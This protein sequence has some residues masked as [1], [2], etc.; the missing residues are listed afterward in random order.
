MAEINGTSG[1][2]TLNGTGDADVIRGLGGDDTINGGGGDDTLEGGDG[3]DTFTGGAGNDFINGRFGHNDVAIFSGNRADYLYENIVINGLNHVRITGLGAFASEGADTLLNVELARFADVTVQLG[4]SANNRPLLGQPMMLDQTVD[5][6]AP[7]TYIIPGTAFFDLD[8]DDALTLRATLADGAAL[9]S[10]LSFDAATR[11]FSGTPPVTT[12][13]QTLSVRVY[14][15]DDDLYDPEYEISDDFMITINQAAGAD[16]V[17]TAGNNILFGT[18]RNERM[19]GHSGDDVFYGS[20]GADI[21][22][23]NGSI[24]PGGDFVNYSASEAA[25]S[26]NLLTG[27]AS[28]GD[29]QGDVLNSI[30][31]VIG[32]RFADTILGTGGGD[33]LWGGLGDDTLD[34]I[35]GDDQIFG[36]G[37]N[38]TVIGGIGQDRLS[39]GAGSDQIN[40]GDGFDVLFAGE[41]SP[42]FTAPPN[43]SPAD[44][45]YA[46]SDLILD[47]GAEAD[48]LFGGN[49]DDALF[50]GYNDSADGGAHD[51]RGDSLYVSLMGASAGVQVDFTQPTVTLGSGTVT[52]FENVN[53]VEGSNFDDNITMRSTTGTF[54][55]AAVY[56]MGGNDQIVAGTWTTEIYGGD[57]H[58]GLDAT[59]SMA[60]IIVEGGA[61][62]DN[63]FINAGSY[64][65]RLDGGSGL[66]TL[67]SSGD[68]S[69]FN[70]GEFTGF[71]QIYMTDGQLRFTGSQFTYGLAT[72]TAIVGQGI[73][74]VEMDPGV[75]FA[76]KGFL[77]PGN[78]SFIVNGTS[79]NDVFKLG[80]ARHTINAGD[81]TDQIKGGAGIDTIDGGAGI[82][83]I[84]GGGGADILTGGAGNDVFRYLAVSDSTLA[85]ADRITDFAI[86]GD[87]LNFAKIDTN[88]TLAGDQAFTFIGNAAFGNTGVAQ[89]RFTDSFGDLLVQ[90]DVNGDGIADMEI[91]LQGLAG[92]T[93]TAADF[94]L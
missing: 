39:G 64:A 68:L 54:M 82:D 73:I 42:G 77:L 79:G 66:D 89:I 90:A 26:V 6:S 93:M 52:G 53:F 43:F 29:A 58:D 56:G 2:D 17:A 15:S 25:I 60:Q 20:P 9:P 36:E 75:Y 30:E 67:Y 63:V 32:T 10:W 80:A 94:V 50:I 31:G 84:S 87:K 41:N 71:E 57:G 70:F 72:N 61:G 49:H 45:R 7:F 62:N 27:A 28:G 74:R 47:T 16:I 85:I 51:L 24:A 4:G 48:S 33:L 37:G 55:R 69:S 91:I 78:V 92:Q 23:G 13:G 34:G 3:V 88:L 18:F 21:I 46:R 44:V 81:G 59:G 12:I 76:T 1:N 35:G 65:Q 8:L 86:G 40:G 19:I 14:A 38:D 22:F 11:T 83:K 5:D